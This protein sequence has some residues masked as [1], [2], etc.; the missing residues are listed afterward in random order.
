MS[1]RR[2]RFARAAR[3]VHRVR[4]RPRRRRPAR[5][6]GRDRARRAGDLHRVVAAR[7]PLA[8]T[9]A[10]LVHGELAGCWALG[11][12][13]PLLRRPGLGGPRPQPAEPLLVEDGRAAGPLVRD[14]PGRRG[15]GPGAGRAGRGRDRARDGRPPGP[16]GR[17]RTGPG[18]RPR[19]PGRRAAGRPPAPGRVP[20]APR[21]AAGLRPGASRLGDAPREAP[22]RVSRPD[23]RRHPPDRST[24]S[25]RRRA[26]RGAPGRRSSPAS[27]WSRGSSRTCRSSSSGRAWTGRPPPVAAE[28]LAAWLGAELE[29]F[30]AH[31]H[32]G[33]VMGEE[34]FRQVAD[35]VRAFLE[36]HRL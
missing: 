8:A 25:A 32:Y 21:R 18:R 3:P 36:T 28:R 30:G 22:A 24:S 23:P 33:L 19:A 7:A 27:R 29:L 6:Q 13:P 11:A 31:S 14:L 1:D 17:R 4:E 15:R 20:R 12:L 2:P 10:L 16:Q 34:S 5:P 26:N 35:R 9:A